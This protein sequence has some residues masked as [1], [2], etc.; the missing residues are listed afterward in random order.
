[1]ATVCVLNNDILR[2]TSCGY[3]LPKI[4]EIYLANFDDVVSTEPLAEGASGITEGQDEI[5]AITLVSGATFKK[6]VPAK[7]S[8][9]FEDTLVVADNGNKNRHANVTFSILGKYS[10]ELHAA[11]DALSL[12][13][14]FAVVKTADGNYLALG[15]ENPVEATVATVQGGS[16]TNGIT[17]T[18]EADTAESPLTLTQ[19]AINKVLGN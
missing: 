11:L 15:R 8:A 5:S 14:Y 9:S 17:V 10:K 6:I 2:T 1:M 16:D 13:R 7:D 4:V 18:L 12:G 19:D 3:S